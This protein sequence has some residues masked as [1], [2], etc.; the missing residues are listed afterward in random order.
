V[1]GEDRQ[2]NVVLTADTSN[3][4]QQMVAAGQQTNSVTDSVNKLITSLDRL[5]RTAGRKLEI[6]SATTTAGIIGA[7]LAAAKFEQQMST[8]Q[9][10]A[11]ITGANVKRISTD[12]DQLRRSLP[13]TTDQVIALVTALQK[14]GT[15]QGNVQKMAETFIKLAAVTG[16]DL[17]TLATNMVQLQRSMGTMAG[18]TDKFAA[19]VA[20]LSANLGVSATGVVQFANSLA[21]VARQVGMTQ[22]EVLGFSAAFQRAG[23]D[24]YAAANVFNKMLTDISRATRYGSND[25]YA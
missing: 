9:A 15:S 10:T 22:T 14:M 11:A 3:Y 1:S 25:I 8:L 23:Q 4:S 2:A 5:T 24:G 18:S 19:S 13:V 12:V 21:P 7:T 6:I 17:G 20:S 16:E